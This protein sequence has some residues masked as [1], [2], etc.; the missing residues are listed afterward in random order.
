M[1]K[2][3]M[4]MK[5]TVSFFITK[6]EYD[7]V[8]FKEERGQILLMKEMQDIQKSLLKST[9]NPLFLFLGIQFL[10]SSQKLF[11]RFFFLNSFLH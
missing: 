10:D 1:K 9:K 11:L 2:R 7:F 4:G 8:Y 6:T 3:N 5:K